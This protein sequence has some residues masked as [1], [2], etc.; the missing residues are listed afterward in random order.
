MPKAGQPGLPLKH[1]MLHMLRH[2]LLL[3]QVQRPQCVCYKTFVVYLHVANISFSGEHALFCKIF[4]DVRPRPSEGHRL[5]ILFPALDDQ[6]RFI[7]IAN[8][9]DD[10]S[11]Q[12][13]LDARVDPFNSVT[14]WFA[15]FDESGESDM[16]KCR[17]VSG[18]YVK[19]FIGL[20]KSD[21]NRSLG[22][23]VNGRPVSFYR[24]NVALAASILT[25][26]TD[27]LAPVDALPQDLP[28]LLQCIAREELRDGSNVKM[29]LMDFESDEG[30]EL[31]DDEEQ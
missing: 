9:Q 23:V 21:Q 22:L 8:C 3:C 15:G 4:T 30:D 24:G 12:K 7:W 28:K 16:A 26:D 17:V 29:E 10:T 5:H 31:E 19:R 18:W 25:F 11:R 27:K 6:M 2:H 14:E 20:P 1:H 13:A